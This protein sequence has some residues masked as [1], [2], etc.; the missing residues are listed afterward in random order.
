MSMITRII[1]L[2]C[3]CKIRDVTREGLS[4]TLEC[5][6]ALDEWLTG[7]PSLGIGWLCVPKRF[8]RSFFLRAV[9]E[10][11][12]MPKKLGQVS[13]VTST[14]MARRMFSLNR[15][16]RRHK[17]P[18]QSLSRVRQ[19]T[20]MASSSGCADGESAGEL[21]TPSHTDDALLLN[22]AANVSVFRDTKEGE[23]P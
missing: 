9:Y 16:D 17:A 7:H 18:D 22:Y 3:T 19:F 14:K 23:R 15:G 13:P 4:R 1:A 11:S 8:A 20:H 12:R 2:H 6:S 21:P 10:V 5:A